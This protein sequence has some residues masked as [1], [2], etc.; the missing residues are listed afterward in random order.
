MVVEESNFR[1]FI[2]FYEKLQLINKTSKNKLWFRGQRDA[3]WK[4][5]PSIYRK[6]YKDDNEVI[7]EET[8]ILSYLRRRGYPFI[9]D[10]PESFDELFIA[11]H[12]G[13]PTRLVDWTEN[14]LLGLYFA[15]DGWTG[16]CDIA[17]Y[18]L[19]PAKWNEQVLTGRQNN[20]HKILPLSDSLVDSLSPDKIS[21]SH[22]TPLNIQANRNNDRIVAQRG[23]FTLFGTARISMDDHYSSITMPEGAKWETALH[24]IIIKKSAVGNFR[25]ALDGF[26][27]T[28]ST[29]Y[30]NL[31]SVAKEVRRIRGFR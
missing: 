27:I 10:K 31:D 7:L 2:K 19:D 29:I 24:K 12:Y 4:I 23:E 28:E 22:N 18:A 17:V 3:S 21:G 30:P 14:P 9:K 15:L 6:E 25:D 16:D 5:S 8:E 13:F 1:S 11:Q 26:G 20:Y